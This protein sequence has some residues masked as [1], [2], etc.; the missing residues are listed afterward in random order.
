[1]AVEPE[2]VV[3]PGTGVHLSL[4]PSR[5]IP[6][7]QR[8]NP[9]GG[10]DFDP[11]RGWCPH[12]EEGHYSPGTSN[13]TGNRHVSSESGTRCPEY[14]EPVSTSPHPLAGIG[15]P[16]GMGSTVSAQP[17]RLR[18]PTGRRVAIVI[19]WPPRANATTWPAAEPTAVSGV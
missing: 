14:L 8:V 2:G 1:T 10:L 9:S 7:Q 18:R 6:G 11:V 17:P 5:A 12:A 3:R 4:P 13:A 16:V 15:C 19:A